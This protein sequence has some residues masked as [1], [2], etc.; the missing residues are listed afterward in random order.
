MVSKMNQLQKRLRLSSSVTALV[1]FLV[2]SG[3]PQEVNAAGLGNIVVFSLLGQPLRAEVEVSATREELAGMN[4]RL[5][6]ASAFKE[7]NV[8]YV[9]SLSGIKFS[10]DKRPNGQS[11][12]KLK[13]DKP[14]NE[15]FVDLLLE[16]NWPTGRLMR[17]YTFLLDPPELTTK[18]LVPVTPAKASSPPLTGSSSSAATRSASM[19]DDEQRSKALAQAKG[20]E[21]KRKAQDQPTDGQ[22]VHEVKRGATMQ[23]IASKTKPEGISLEQMLVGLWQ[24]NPQAFDGGNMNRL[25]AGQTL[26]TPDKATLEA[27]STQEARKIIVAQAADWNAYRRK[28]SAEA[29]HGPAR[30]DVGQRDTAGRITAKVDDTA[31]PVAKPKDQLRVSRTGANGST[32]GKPS[33]EDLIARDKAL[34]ETNERIASLETNI[35]SMQKLIEMKD[36]QLAALQTPT[37]SAPATPETQL[38]PEQLAGASMAASEPASA[39]TEKAAERPLNQLEAKPGINSELAQLTQPQ[40][41]QKVSLVKGSFGSPLILL[42]GALLVLLAFLAGYF[43]NIRR[44]GSQTT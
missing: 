18:K 25:K 20:H 37:V 17:E 3:L 1:S 30:E 22:D 39:V 34:Q 19:I 5:A 7:A 23:K 28:L 36:L 15:P 33:E 24:A 31:A 9:I 4:A 14:I 43:L 32:K 44:T 8:D 42:A 29:A 13:S 38:K 12:I 16:L 40:P 41:V 10:M 6:P 27:T 21:S 35:A 2:F 11:I 26:A